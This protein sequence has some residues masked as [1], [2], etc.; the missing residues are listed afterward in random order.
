L[1]GLH[2]TDTTTKTTSADGA[3]LVNASL[4]SGSTLTA[5][6]ADANIIAFANNGVTR[7]IL[8]GEGSAHA[9]VEWTTFAGEDDF[10]IIKDVEATLVPDVFGEAVQYKEDDLVKLGL[11]GECSIRKEPYGRMRGMMNTTKMTMLHH[12]TLNKMI[13]AIRDLTLRLETAE[14]KLLEGA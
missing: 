1:R 10:Q 8:D 6:G 3:I 11:F 7:F 4:K 5:L 13:D 9:D 2:T 14:A 12:G